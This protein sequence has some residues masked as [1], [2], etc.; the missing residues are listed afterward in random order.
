MSGVNTKDK[1]LFVIQHKYW[2]EAMQRPLAAEV[3]KGQG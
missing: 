3:G 1:G 2:K